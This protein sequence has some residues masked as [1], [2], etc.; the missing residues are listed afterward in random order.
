MRSTKSDWKKKIIRVVLLLLVSASTASAGGPSPD[1]LKK[2]RMAHIDPGIK[3][4]ELRL[5]DLNR[6]QV[7]LSQLR[8]KAVLLYFWASW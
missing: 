3:A 8:G 1:D 7:S 6:N 4:P 2:L 5:T